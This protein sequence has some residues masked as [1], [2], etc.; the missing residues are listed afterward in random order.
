MPKKLVEYFATGGLPRGGHIKLLGCQI[1]LQEASFVWTLGSK[2]SSRNDQNSWHYQKLPWKRTTYLRSFIHNS[3][4]SFNS[5]SLSAA[6][7]KLLLSRKR[8]I[9]YTRSTRGFSLWKSK[10][11]RIGGPSLKWSKSIEKHS[12]KANEEATLV[13]AAVERK[14]REKK[15]PTRTDS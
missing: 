10:V 3:S 7:K 13:V 14:K 12:K 15:N 5:G 8:D 11:L 4:S 6:G 2:N 9:V 1:N